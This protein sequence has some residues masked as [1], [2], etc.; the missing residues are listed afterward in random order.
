MTRKAIHICG[1][2]HANTYGASEQ[3]DVLKGTGF[4]PYIKPAKS[5]WALAPEGMSNA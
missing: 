2:V 5:A 3:V 1:E 4:S